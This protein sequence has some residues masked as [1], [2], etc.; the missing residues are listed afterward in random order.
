MIAVS[1]YFEVLCCGGSS[2]FSHWLQEA[3]ERP[4]L[5]SFRKFN[6]VMI[7]GPL[8]DDICS[9]MKQAASTHT[10]LLSFKYQGNYK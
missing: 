10:M 6:F 1:K 7:W 8:N 4:I 2:I 9:P 5:G 3:E